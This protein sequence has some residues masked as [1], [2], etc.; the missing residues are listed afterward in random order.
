[1]TRNY[2][3]WSKFMLSRIYF[4][5]VT[6]IL[7]YKRNLGS[8]VDNAI[9]LLDERGEGLDS[10]PASGKIFFTV[11]FQTSL[12]TTSPNFKMYRS[13]FRGQGGRGVNLTIHLHL[14]PRLK[15]CED[16]PL[17]LLYS[18]VTWTGKNLPFKTLST[19]TRQRKLKVLYKILYHL[20]YVLIL[21]IFCH[22]VVPDLKPVILHVRNVAQC[23][24]HCIL[25]LL[26]TDL[27]PGLRLIIKQYLKASAPAIYDQEGCFYPKPNFNSIKSWTGLSIWEF[28]GI[29][30]S[31]TNT[32]TRKKKKRKLLLIV[33]QI[34]KVWG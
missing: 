32:H 27:Y 28:T 6:R 31:H 14:L 9:K 16:V 26:Y 20:L 18:L 24:V 21:F 22:N 2:I 29:K 19:I 34:Q 10:D 17:R 33:C 25:T 13:H 30:T 12:R 8:S 1:M 3:W 23:E 15:L 11:T 5:G 4:L 7:T